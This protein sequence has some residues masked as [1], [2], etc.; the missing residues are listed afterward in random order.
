[1][2]DDWEPLVRK[3][4][5][6]LID[7]SVSVSCCVT[8][9]KCYV[10]VHHSPL[11]PLPHMPHGSPANWPRCLH[12]TVIQHVVGL[13]LCFHQELIPSLVN[14]ASPLGLQEYLLWGAVRESYVCAQLPLLPD[15]PIIIS[16]RHPWP[17]PP[18]APTRAWPQLRVCL[19]QAH[20]SSPPYAIFGVYCILIAA[21]TPGTSQSVRDVTG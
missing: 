1:M 13:W 10:L 20:P 16:H 3:C 19:T 5:F 14:L 7:D 15:K 2:L 6:H 17:G 8:I 12:C 9:A 18:P 21:E 4:T 11:P